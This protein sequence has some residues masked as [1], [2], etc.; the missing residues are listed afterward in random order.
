LLAFHSA[1]NQAQYLSRSRLPRSVNASSGYRTGSLSPSREH[2]LVAIK[3][4]CPHISA[5]ARHITSFAEMMTARTGD[6]D[7]EGWLTAVEAGDQPDLR[8]F[9]VGIRNDQQAASRSI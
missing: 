1:E 6:R 5:L 8:S 3:D 4:H 7:L 2:A 9:A